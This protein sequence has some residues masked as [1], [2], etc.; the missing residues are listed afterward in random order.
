MQ[1]QVKRLREALEL[2]GPVVPKKATLP[3]LINVL[4]KDGQAIATDL[5]VA[6]A[7]DLPDVEG[8]CVLPYH[9]VADL[10]KRVPGAETLT[11][12]QEGNKLNLT[13][14]SGKASYEV[15]E[16]EDYPPLPKV[17]ATLF[18]KVEHTVDGDALVRALL[19]VVD[20][21]ST[22]ESRPVLTGV[23]LILSENVQVAGADGYRLALK[24][25]PMALP[26]AEGLRE[27]IIPAK[28][29]RVLGHLWKKTPR[30]TPLDSS[31]VRLITAKKQLELSLNPKMLKASFGAVTLITML[32]EGTPPTYRQLF[33]EDTPQKVRVF[34]P[35]FERA[36]RR[37][38]AVSKR[39][40]GALRL[41]WSE[42]VMT[43][44]SKSDE[45]SAEAVVAVAAE[46]GEGWVALDV[47]YILDYLRGKEGLVE[48]GVSDKTSPILFR[49]GS[50]PLVLIMP[51][52]VEWEPES[53]VVAEAEQVVE[54]A[55]AETETEEKPKRSRKQK[56]S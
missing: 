49:H 45:E 52:F 12:E 55:Q 5:E 2:L 6:V 37:V 4:L 25:L 29:V 34:A 8:Q 3:V 50:S 20:Y 10:L 27:V 53:A 23:T 18:G 51:M 54:Q 22:K 17:D 42:G 16:P 39:G 26:A 7:V 11:L 13:W 14:S 19:S 44:S 32:I 43:V 1:I 30:V 48:M 33:P 21:C 24:T 41:T 35:D 28:A 15:P 38:Q 31:L 36:V 40:K 9:S 56:Q 47:D 46:G